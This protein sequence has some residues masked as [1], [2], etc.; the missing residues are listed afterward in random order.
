M[1]T[2]YGWA[3]VVRT[4]GRGRRRCRS[5]ARRWCCVPAS[6]PR[7]G[8]TSIVPGDFT[9]D[10]PDQEIRHPPGTGFAQSTAPARPEVSRRPAG[11]GREPPST[12]RRLAAWRA[13]RGVRRRLLLA[14]LPRAQPLAQG[15]HELGASEAPWHCPPRPRH[16]HPTQCRGLARRQDP[17]PAEA[18]RAIEQLV[19]R[20]NHREATAPDSH[21]H[22]RACP[23]GTRTP[24]PVTRAYQAIARRTREKPLASDMTWCPRGDLNPHPLLGD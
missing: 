9:G 1:I 7:P 21:A 11:A 2:I 13:G 22:H 8:T 18:A 14:L 16:R 3:V 19:R 4:R 15:Q 10:A 6:R 23:S 24:T 12:R 17:D 5:I 20:P